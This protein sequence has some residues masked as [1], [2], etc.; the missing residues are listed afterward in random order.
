M[1]VSE[2]SNSP[3]KNNF[4][5][6]I[7]NMK[8]NDQGNLESESSNTERNINSKKEINSENINNDNKENKTNINKINNINNN[9]NNKNITSIVIEKSNNI[10]E[11][12]V[13]GKDNHD[14]LIKFSNE[15]KSKRSFYI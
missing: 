5:V 1:D 11:I 8:T 10:S 4:K 6:K 2:S 14:I 9:N 12:K 7:L 3:D 13:K 15:N